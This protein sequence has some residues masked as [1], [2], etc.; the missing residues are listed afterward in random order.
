DMPEAS[1]IAEG[2]ARFLDGP[3]A[4]AI[5][6]QG[7][8]MLR[9]EPFVLSIG[10]SPAPDGTPRVLGLR[11]AVDFVVFRPD[12]TVDGIDYQ[13]PRPRPDLGVYASQLPASAPSMYG[14]EPN[15]RIRAGVIFL[16]SP[17]AAA[18]PVFLGAEGPD[19]TMTRA[20]HERFSSELATLGEQFAEARWADR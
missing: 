13:L 1:R 16:A 9:E 3:Y 7:L 14:R 17:K 20:E 15:L 12:G 10:L 4:R 5:R 6:D 8:H 19:G 11:G 2:V 18:E